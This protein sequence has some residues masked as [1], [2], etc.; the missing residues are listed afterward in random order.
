M[1]V[2]LVTLG[3]DKNSVDTEYLAALLED[4]GHEL[5]LDPEPDAT[6]ALDAVVITTCGFIADAKR[7]SVQA[8]VDWA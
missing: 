3:C 8:V 4:A 7:Q 2:G 1:R 6:G 5:S